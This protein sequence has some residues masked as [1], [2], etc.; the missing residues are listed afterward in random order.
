MPRAPVTMA[1]GSV[2]PSARRAGAARHDVASG[3]AHLVVELDL[4]VPPRERV[5][6]AEL[7]DVG[8]DALAPGHLDDQLGVAAAGQSGVHRGGEGAAE[9]RVDVGDAEADLRVAERLDS[10]GAADA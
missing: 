4:P 10:A 8:L 1:A 7:A 6:V 3:G 2:S 5:A 9:A